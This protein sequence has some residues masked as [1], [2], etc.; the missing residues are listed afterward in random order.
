VRASSKTDFLR[1]GQSDV[2][3]AERIDSA[4]TN[5]LFPRA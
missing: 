5:A 1:D 2:L 4:A 3:F